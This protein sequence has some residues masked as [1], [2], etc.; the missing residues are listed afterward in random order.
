MILAT[1]HNPDGRGLSAKAE[2][3]LA[4]RD[5]V[6]ARWERETRARVDGA[7]RLLRP[8]L[9]NMLPAFL[10][11]IA[12]ALSPD[13]PRRDATSH[14]NAAAVHGSERARMTSFGP[15]QVIH[16]YHILRESVAAVA[17]GQVDL[18]EDDWAIIDRS[19]N[20][21]VREAVREF[22]SMQEDLRRKLAGA[23]SHDMRTPLANIT[24]AAGLIRL[25]ND[26]AASK[27]YADKVQSNAQRLNDM[28]SELLD[29]LTFNGGDKL[30]LTLSPFDISTLVREV[31]ADHLRPGG[32]EFEL[33]LDPIQGYWCDSTLRRALENLINN[34]ARYGDGGTVGIFAKAIRGRLMISVHN[35]GSFIPKERLDEIF[36]YYT[37]GGHDAVQGWGLGLPFVKRVAQSHGGSIAVDSSES[38]G[39][40]FLMDIPVDCRPFVDATPSAV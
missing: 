13:C 39:T 24:T 25:T 8:V 6:I 3:F 10:D 21:A 11:N 16:E 34:A 2:Q 27:R 19:I 17:K 40:T 9:T 36:D 4:L 26:A 31:C 20:S 15:D 22:S 30:Q 33:D 12:E 28:M 37:R 23:L 32:I 5:P 35:T 18:T 7:A 1:D 38:A 29:A 14:T